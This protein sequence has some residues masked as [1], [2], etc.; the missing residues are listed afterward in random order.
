MNCP[1]FYYKFSLHQKVEPFLRASDV[2]RSDCIWWE[3]LSVVLCSRADGKFMWWC[4][5]MWESAFENWG[6]PSKIKMAAAIFRSSPLPVLWPLSL[7][8]S[9]SGCAV[10]CNAIELSSRVLLPKYSS[11]LLFSLCRGGDVF[12]VIKWFNS[13]LGAVFLR[14]F[15]T[16]SIY[17]YGVIRK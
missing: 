14:V 10:T 12:L 9:F 2:D 11:F 3:L 1:L 8:R 5:W 4:W 13:Q 6:A 17:S 16:L 15:I 7:S